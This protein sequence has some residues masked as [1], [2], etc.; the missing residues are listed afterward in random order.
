MKLHIIIVC[1]IIANIVCLPVPIEFRCNKECQLNY[2]FKFGYLQ[3]ENNNIV[4]LLQEQ[5]IQTGIMNLQR[6]AGLEPNGILNPE[7][8]ILLQTPRC[9]IKWS[10]QTRKK[11]FTTVDSWNN[12]KNYLNETIITYYLDLSNF[13]KI[14]NGENLTKNVINSIFSTVMNQWS[15]TAL[16]NIQQVL[17]ITQANITIQFLQNNHGDGFDFDGSGG[18]LA[19]AFFPGDSI[20]RRGNVH[21]DLG[22]KWTL[23]DEKNGIS[24]YSVSLHEIGHALGLGHTTD[25]K[26][27]MYAWYQDNKFKLEN[28]DKN[29]INS[30]YGMKQKYKYA[31]ITP[32]STP[33]TTTNIPTTKFE[34]TTKQYDLK[35]IKKFLIQNSRV[36]IYPKTGLT[37]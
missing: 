13:E 23:W 25:N 18:V 15:E 4:G 21:F 24:L 10:S 9:G 8:L 3:P 32:T 20:G 29:G 35:K 33:T 30:L 26:A 36:Y 14:R 12:P 27:V 17:D 6:D 31:D 16:I 2:L 28:D 19:H 22:E 7:T 34:T 1:A 37:F 11:R 5:N